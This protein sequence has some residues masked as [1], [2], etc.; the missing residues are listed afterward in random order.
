MDAVNQ[1]RIQIKPICGLAGL[2]LVL[3]A[4]LKLAGVHLGVSG[5]MN[6]LALVGI[7]LLLI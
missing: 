1:F 7:G 2:V 5:D 6:T 4:A 3:L